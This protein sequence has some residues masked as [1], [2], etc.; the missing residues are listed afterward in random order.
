MATMKKATPE[1]REAYSKC[2]P[3]YPLGYVTS[4]AV[5]KW[6]SGTIQYT[7]D[8]LPVFVEDLRGSWGGGDPVWECIAPHGYMFGG[9]LHTMLCYTLAD[10]RSRL[11]G[12]W[13]EP[14]IERDECGC[15]KEDQQAEREVLREFFDALL[16]GAG[17]KVRR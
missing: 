1:Q 7:G 16:P 4:M 12:E 10:A 8:V 11:A 5:G 6:E 2:K 3:V 15:N 9:E 14:C 13:L 17:R